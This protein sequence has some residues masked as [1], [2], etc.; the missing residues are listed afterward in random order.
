MNKIRCKAPGFTLIELMVVA[1][2]IGIL[3]AISIPAYL[4]H[5]ERAMG[6]KALENLHLIRTAQMIYMTDSTEFS[7]NTG[8]LQSYSDF[9]VNDGDWAYTLENFT[10]STF[11]AVATR[12]CPQQPN[13]DGQ[14]IT[15]DQDS[16]ITFPGG[17]D[18]YPP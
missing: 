2:I 9:E 8:I 13:Y 10:A 14:R 18:S 7:N 12:N 6:S 4:Q 11:T 15:L 3:V 5:A 1:I 16:V 17:G